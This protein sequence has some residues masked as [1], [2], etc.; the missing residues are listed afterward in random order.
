[1]TLYPNDQIYM[2]NCFGGWTVNPVFTA[3]S[4]AGIA[5]A[6]KSFSHGR[7]QDILQWLSRIALLTAFFF[8]KYIYVTLKNL[9]FF[10]KETRMLH[11]EGLYSRVPSSQLDIAVSPFQTHLN[12]YLSFVN[13]DIHIW[14]LRLCVNC[15][16]S[17]SWRI[18]SR[19]D[20]HCMR[21]NDRPTTKL[22]LYFYYWLW[23]WLFITD[24]IVTVTIN[25][26]EELKR[27][28]SEFS[29]W[30]FVIKIGQN[31]FFFPSG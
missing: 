22:L 19:L 24:F 10:Q 29:I 28:R 3:S 23:L 17:P 14:N 7:L 1:M 6:K 31:I 26:G 11:E 12:S 20:T 13:C 2:K 15:K 18:I 9:L 25:S 16:V 4:I 8:W 5:N 21:T 30:S 27:G